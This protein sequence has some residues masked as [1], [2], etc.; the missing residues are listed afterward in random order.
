MLA[1]AVFSK[2]FTSAL[3]RVLALDPEHARLLK[4][5]AGKIIAVE[6]LPFG[7]RITLSPILDT[8]LVLA[9]FPGPA[10]VTLRGSPLAFARLAFSS[11]PQNRLFQGEIEVIGDVNVARRLQILLQQLDLDWEAWL[12]D[13]AGEQLARRV[14]DSIRG[15]S[16]WHRHAWQTFQ[17]NLTEFL[18]EETRALPPPLEAE[19][20]YRRID[21]LRDDVAR[22][23]ARVRRLKDKR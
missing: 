11:R 1:Q 20:L 21:R 4:P 22:L 13:R 14:A 5:L 6:L 10:D 9:D 17:W 19:D 8:V 23:E 18:Q 3:T 15:V 2:A 12:A 7:H 16:A